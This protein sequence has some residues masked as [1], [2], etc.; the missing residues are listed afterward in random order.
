MC[1]IREHT[2]HGPYVLGGYCLGGIVAVETARQLVSM[3]EE[4]LLVVLFDAPTPGYP[5]A[6]RRVAPYWRGLR[7]RFLGAGDFAVPVSGQYIPQPLA[8]PVVQ[9]NSRDE[10]MATRILRVFVDSRRGWRDVCSG[11]FQVFAAAG[12]H[13]TMLLSPHVAETAVALRQSLERVR[14]RSRP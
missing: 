4:V 2:P 6:L 14:S 13:V 8:V 5:R 12:S 11:E 10:G 7:R 3:G 9:F 1:S